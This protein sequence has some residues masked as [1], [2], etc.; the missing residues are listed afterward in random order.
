[1]TDITF[2]KD[3]PTFA[4]F[5]EATRKT[6]RTVRNWANQP[7]GLPILYFG[8][9]PRVNLK[10]VPEWLER[11]TKQRNPRRKAS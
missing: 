3:Y 8:R 4:E 5:A 1:M 2:L 9:E 6:P 10:R 7:D 11:R